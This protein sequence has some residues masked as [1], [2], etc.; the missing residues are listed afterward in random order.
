MASDKESSLAIAPSTTSAPNSQAHGLP[1][2]PLAA[3]KTNIAQESSSKSAPSPVDRKE[4]IARLQAAKMSKQ[5]SAVKEVSQKEI[6]AGDQGPGPSVSSTPQTSTTGSVKPAVAKSDAEKARQTE[7]IKQ[8]LELLKAQGKIPSSGPS[9]PQPS[10]RVNPAPK[11]SQTVSTSDS[12]TKS[13]P[14][15]AGPISRIPGLF[16][17]SS[18]APALSNVAMDRANAPPENNTVS[19]LRKRPVASDLDDD[20]LPPKPS[21]AYTRPL[22]QSPHEHHGESLIIQVSDDESG[23]SDMDLDDIQ[24]EQQHITTSPATA[25][26]N[27]NQLSRKFPQVTEFSSRSASVNPTRST[28]NTPPTT[29]TPAGFTADELLKHEKAILDLK[30]KIAK[31]TEKKKA[32]EASKGSISSSPAPRQSGSTEKR[33]QRRV[34]LETALR[35]LDQGLEKENGRLAQ[36]KKEITEIRTKRERYQRDREDLMKELEE[37]GIETEGMGDEELQAQKDEIDQNN[38]HFT[39]SQSADL[40][41]TLA[42]TIRSL[43]TASNF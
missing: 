7:L 1:E 33:M 15:K 30:S 39:G 21:R 22:G 2:K 32:A 23:G 10:D 24:T 20:I 18:P 9:T 26:H 17:N 35:S 43:G 12:S 13:E 19:S 29:R 36:L 16:M 38:N 25:M 11:P 34:E 28:L 5:S 41:P 6:S 3:I 40:V 8:R 37:Y 4:Y 14:N 42:R 27:G 31:M